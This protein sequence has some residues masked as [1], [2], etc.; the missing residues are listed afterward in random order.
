[1]SENNLQREPISARIRKIFSY[2][3]EIALLEKDLKK[4]DPKRMN[5][6]SGFAYLRGACSSLTPFVMSLVSSASP[7][8][9][10][11]YIGLSAGFSGIMKAGGD[12]FKNMASK[13]L[14]KKKEED[15]Y[16]DFLSSSSNDTLSLNNELPKATKAM[17]EIISYRS[18]RKTTLT[19]LVFNAGV[20]GLTN[21]L[22]LALIAG[23]S[24]TQFSF[25]LFKLNATEEKQEKSVES[26]NDFRRK[27]V[28]LL[29]A[30]D[31]LRE[32]NNEE[33]AFSE[34][35]KS[36]EKSEKNDHS[37]LKTIFR[38]RCI[39]LPFI[40][41]S[42]AVLW[43]GPAIGNS[44]TGVL[45]AAF[46]FAG[47]V[48][49]ANHVAASTTDLIDNI[50]NSIEKYREYKE[51]MK[52]MKYSDVQVKTGD[53]ELQ[54][55]NGHLM[56]KDVSFTYPGSNKGVS[57]INLEFQ[58]GK[59][60]LITGESGSG[61]STI[62]NLL[63]HQLDAKAGEVSIDGI[64]VCDLTKSSLNK[65]ISYLS[66]QPQFIKGTVRE[67]LLLFKRE[68]TD[69]QLYEVLKQAGLEN[70]SLDLKTHDKDGQISLSGG[71]AQRLALA[72]VLLKDSP[73]ILMD[74]PTSK[75][76]SSSRD[77]VWKTISEI[78]KD[79]TIVI[80]SHDGYEILNADNVAVVSKG[81]LTETGN[82]KELLKNKDS[83]LRSVQNRIKNSDA[84]KLTAMELLKQI[85]SLSISVGNSIDAET[86]KTIK[87]V[88]NSFFISLKN[89]QK[90][91]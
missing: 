13:P 56:M 19:T 49:A 42:S 16:K 8:A 45:G 66:Q 1:M 67:E 75:L 89:N 69:D 55:S 83:Y 60:N 40:A 5:L 4:E 43:G 73:I 36:R 30:T 62:F 63:R 7:A 90:T 74:E 24:A 23:M 82:P 22:F 14:P 71:Q 87:T 46:F 68:A 54:T 15:V 88:P 50:S 34:L 58:K 79:K 57:D 39:Q 29:E 20:L 61:K 47:S 81:L 91:D 52:N 18:A 44:L 53:K 3:K 65:A 35:R 76:D 17:E 27:K 80:V 10:I 41:I 38:Q 70:I 32:T 72:R 33:Y 28:T 31:I 85:S 9:M 37:L 26:E 86:E 77:A 78:K 25:E 21:P 11:A 2:N 64:N 6:M 48:M 51:C 84:D 59:I 12:Y